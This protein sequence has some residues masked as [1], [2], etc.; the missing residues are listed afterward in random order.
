MTN[1]WTSS[2][3]YHP[4]GGSVMKNSEW[5]ELQEQNTQLGITGQYHGCTLS[6]FKMAICSLI[7][8]PLL[9]KNHSSQHAQVPFFYH[10]LLYSLSQILRPP[11][12]LLPP[13]IKIRQTS[14]SCFS[15][16][17]FALNSSARSFF[18]TCS[19]EISLLNGFTS[20]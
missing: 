16:P 15:W 10:W 4:Q 3:S 17:L 11:W 13:G 2:L 20:S 9:M 18:F 14:V 1:K 5:N 7:S 6:I 12:S 19:S 8:F